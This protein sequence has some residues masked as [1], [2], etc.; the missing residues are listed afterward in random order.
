M[1]GIAANAP[2]FPNPKT[3]D[4]SVTTATEFP[5]IVSLRA[6][7]GSEA[8]ERQGSATPGV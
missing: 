3:A 2:I 8:I 5:F 6:L 7:E 4:P 1:T